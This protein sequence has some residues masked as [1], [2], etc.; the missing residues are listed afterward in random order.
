MKYLVTKHIFYHFQNMLNSCWTLISTELLLNSKS[1]ILVLRC[2]NVQHI[3]QIFF[4]HSLT[5]SMTVAIFSLAMNSGTCLRYLTIRSYR[6]TYIAGEV[7]WL[8]IKRSFMCQ[9]WTL[10]Q[11]IISEPHYLT[12]VSVDLMLY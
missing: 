3:R 2:V 12:L 5:K 4:L 8:G 11:S 9:I 7:N 10:S 6:C 1:Q